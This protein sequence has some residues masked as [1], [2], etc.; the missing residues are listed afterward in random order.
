MKNNYTPIII[1]NEQ[2]A[3]YYEVLDLAHTTMNYAPFIRLV[4]EL[5]IESKKLWL[6]VLD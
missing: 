5:V 2:R 6:S 1:K 3:N 4:S